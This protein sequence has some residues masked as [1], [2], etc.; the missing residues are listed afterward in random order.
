MSCLC[1]LLRKAGA[2][3]APA[4]ETKRAHKK[5]RST[6]L[7]THTSAHQ[8]ITVARACVC[9]LVFAEVRQKLANSRCYPRCSCK[10]EAEACSEKAHTASSIA[11]V[12]R[13]RGD[14]PQRAATTGAPVKQMTSGV[15]KARGK[16]RLGGKF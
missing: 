15:P 1:K 11:R 5:K 12:W 14:D 16:K 6:G 13:C 10:P 4:T 2:S 9:V 3:V 8:E 7:V